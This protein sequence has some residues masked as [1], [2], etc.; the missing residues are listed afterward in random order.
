[1]RYGNVGVHGNSC[2]LQPEIKIPAAAPLWDASGTL[3][4]EDN[5]QHLKKFLDAFAAWIERFKFARMLLLAVRPLYSLGIDTAEGHRI[6][7]APT[8]GRPKRTA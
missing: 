1:M 5:R 7:C 3:I 4:D 6:V 8:L 2:A